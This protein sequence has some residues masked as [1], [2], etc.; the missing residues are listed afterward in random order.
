[1]RCLWLWFWCNVRAPARTQTD[2]YASIGTRKRRHKGAQ[3]Q[4]RKQKTEE[5]YG[6]I[7]RSC[8][9]WRKEYESIGIAVAQTKNQFRR[10]RLPIGSHCI[11]GAP[12]YVVDCAHNQHGERS[13]VVPLHFVVAV[14]IVFFFCVVV[15]TIKPVESNGQ[16]ALRC[17]VLIKK[18]K[19]TIMRMNFLV[20]I[21]FS[22]GFASRGRRGK[23]KMR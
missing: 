17:I 20:F 12:V 3:W 5:I 21:L 22:C 6:N 16:F 7:I 9:V 15:R 14:V 11:C 4:P 18:S 23:P 10:M 19:P 2:N 8:S 13:V 1:M